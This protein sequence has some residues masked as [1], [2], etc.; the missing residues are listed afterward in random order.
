MCTARNNNNIIISLMRVPRASC[1]CVY[2]QVFHPKFEVNRL[3]FALRLKFAVF[4]FFGNLGS[5]RSAPS[6][7]SVRCSL[8]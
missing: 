4:L 2:I 1:H 6:S 7:S 8:E 3:K 5:A